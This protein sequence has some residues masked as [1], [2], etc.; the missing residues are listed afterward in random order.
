M[1]AGHTLSRSP[2]YP[3]EMRNLSRQTAGVSPDAA[4]LGRGGDGPHPELPH[5]QAASGR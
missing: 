3:R 2:D 5:G 4:G 1:V